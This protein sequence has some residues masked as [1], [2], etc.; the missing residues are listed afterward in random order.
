MEGRSK[1]TLGYEV[2]RA[3][4]YHTIRNQKYLKNWQCYVEDLI[5]SGNVTD[6][7]IYNFDAMCLASSKPDFGLTLQEYS[8][9][10]Y[11]Y[12]NTA[13]LVDAGLSVNR[14]KYDVTYADGRRAIMAKV[15]LPASGCTICRTN[16]LLLV[17]VHSSK[18]NARR[19]NSQI[20]RL[21][22][23]FVDKNL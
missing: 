3:V 23:F 9:I 22:D 18:T 8:H 2:V 12:T 17:G 19:C 21:C 6:A 10:M 13:A 15:G 5:A 7:A 11:G 20:T 16:G 14:V 4:D 1:D